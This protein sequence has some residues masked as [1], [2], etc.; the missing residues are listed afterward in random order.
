MNRATESVDVVLMLGPLYHLRDRPDR[1]QALSEALRIIRR[2]GA[3]SAAISRFAALLDL[4]I[5]LDRLAQPP[6]LDA[7]ATGLTSGEF[8]G[9]GSGLFTTANLHR[10]AEFRLETE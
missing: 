6:V 9:G 2:G 8:S 3:V 10:P 1:L 4:V 5:R 7:M